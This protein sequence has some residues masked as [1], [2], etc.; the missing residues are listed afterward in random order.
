MLPTSPT[1]TGP[2]LLLAT[3]AEKQQRDLL[4]LPEWGQGLSLEQWQQR[5]KVLRAHPWSVASMESWH[6]RSSGGETLASCETFR[7][8]ALLGSEAGHVYAVASVFTEP[9]LR[10]KG[11]ATAMIDALHQALAARPEALGSVLFSDVGARIYERSGYRA[12]PAF[13]WVLPPLSGDPEEGVRPLED[14]HAGAAT[15]G[16]GV[17]F[18]SPRR[19][20]FD[21]HLE[22]ERFYAWV[23]DRPPAP[24]HAAAAGDSYAAWMVSYKE[25]VLRVLTLEARSP[26][27]TAA[28]L[29][30]AQRL[31]HQLR[32]DSVRVWE[33][34]PGFP[35]LPGTRRPRE[36]ELPMARVYGGR[37]LADW[38]FVHRVLWV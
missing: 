7:T 21:W 9:S 33:P 22:R 4:T 17:L 8:P 13:E 32:L 11:H 3:D 12:F 29:G 23:K 16:P 36:G 31:A 18:S 15:P 27:A 28:V 14:L 24:F 26:E 25:N 30:S 10:G 5:E 37:A 20:Q 2:T 1:L 19:E 35:P 38:R 34:H 6:W